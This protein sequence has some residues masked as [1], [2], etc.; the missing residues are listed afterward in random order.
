VGAAEQNPVFAA[1]LLPRRV[2]GMARITL[3]DKKVGSLKVTGKTKDGKSRTRQDYWDAV[4]PSF[5]IRV[6][7]KGQRTYIL[8]GR[9]PGSS[10]YTRR[11][12]ARVGSI[13]LADARTKA[14]RW[15]ELI[16]QGKDPAAEEGR[17][18]RENQRHQ[19][20]TFAQAAADYIESEVIGLNPEYPRQR[21][22]AEVKREFDRVL[23]PL[24]GEN[25]ITAIT[26]DDIEDVVEGVKK[27]GTAKMLASFGIK[28]PPRAH[29]RGRPATRQGK[30][31]PGQARNL[32]GIIK[33]FFGW[34]RRQKRYGLTAN[35]CADLSAKHLIGPK[36]AVDRFLDDA[37]I[38]AFWRATSRMK[39]PYGPF[40]RLLLLSGLRLNECANA[41]WSELDMKGEKW[42]IP[43]ERMKARNEKARAHAV[44]LTSE[45]RKIVD[46]LPRF[47]RGDFLFSTTFGEKPAW[48]NDKVKKRLDARMLRS[49][50]AL[51]R[52]RGDN[53]AKVELKR[54]TNHDL[55]RTLRSGLSRLRI[56]HD[57]KEAIL[58]HVKPGIVGTYDV[59][60]L[61]DEKKDA[62]TRWAAHIRSLVEP[63]PE[64]VV[65]LPAR[66]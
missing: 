27:S 47:K 17:I 62:L 26:H 42:I 21:N 36:M 16:G 33:M 13:S 15:I 43:K 9:F 46:A 31:A 14:R 20:N 44:P 40:F 50:R 53:P 29:K 59:Y 58:S 55:R 8:A 56:D 18:A 63:A 19:E 66:A 52:M 60:D 6:T 5:G 49:L 64:N 41:S 65:P 4:V 25:P 22:G 37:E 32:L 39:Y 11:E 34:V 28:P 57:V 1:L 45:I 12:L 24:W 2:F 23:I 48:V 51:A 61:Y 7:D 3:K 10:A 30:P 35:P 38:A 54:W